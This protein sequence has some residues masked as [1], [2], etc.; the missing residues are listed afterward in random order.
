VNRVIPFSEGNAAGKSAMSRIRHTQ[1]VD[2]IRAGNE[3]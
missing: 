3:K 1:G 2:L